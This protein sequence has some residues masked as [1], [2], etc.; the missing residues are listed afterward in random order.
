M[1]FL[2]KKHY[3]K[4]FFVA[5]VFILLLVVIAAANF[6]VADISFKQTAMILMSKIPIINGLIDM[7]GI[8]ATSVIILLQLR[9]PRIILAC[10]VGAALSV[11]GAA[12]QGI[13]KNPMADPF[14][15]GVS[16]GAALGASI[17]MVFLKEIEFLGLSVIAFNAFLGAITTTF[18][19]YNIAKV[20]RK[21]PTATLLLAGISLNYLLSSIISLIMIFNRQEIERIIM[22]T[23]G[24]FSTGS[25]KEVFLL[26]IIVI[27]SIILI[28]MFARDL[29][30]MLLGEENARSL[31]VNVEGLKKY[32]LIISTIMIA[33][34]VSVSGIIGFVGLIIPHGVRMFTGPDNR[35]VIPF[36]AITGAI[37]LIICDTMARSLVPPSEIPVGIITSIFGVPFFIY[38][39]YKTKKKVF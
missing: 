30:V 24:S 37:F 32:I 28:T 34:V 33:A 16:S 1:T 19:V 39:L 21:V 8:K 13:F 17:T 3:Y 25:W 10:L 18:L 9:L 4:R 27:P 23:M 20:G 26:L 36:S 14:V 38:L 11:V 15:L 35:V 12:F 22:W 29:N 31:G 5:G 7:K 6:G 2:Q